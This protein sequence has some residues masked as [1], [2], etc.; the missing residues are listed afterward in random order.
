[1][2]VPVLANEKKHFPV[3]VFYDVLGMGFRLQ[4][5]CDWQTEPCQFLQD[6]GESMDDH[7]EDA[8]R[9]AAA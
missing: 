6:A 8:E 5:N 4:C 9:D 2:S 3:D 7:M 1:M